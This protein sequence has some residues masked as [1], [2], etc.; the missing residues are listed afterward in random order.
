[1]KKK[2]FSTQNALQYAIKQIEKK[3]QKSRPSVITEAIDRIKSGIKTKKNIY[4]NIKNDTMLN[5][6]TDISK[7]NILKLID[8]Y[9]LKVKYSIQKNWAYP[10]Q[11]VGEKKNLNTILIIKIKKNGEISSIWFDKRSGNSFLDESAYRAIQKANPLPPLPSG[12][13]MPYFDVG[14]SFTPLGLN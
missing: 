4:N 9:K 10:E 5:I 14:L 6:G 12:Y 1:M 7:K 8:I 11:I 3:T 2:S 13:K